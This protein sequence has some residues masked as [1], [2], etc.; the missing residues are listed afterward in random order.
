MT[1]ELHAPLPTGIVLPSDE[2]AARELIE[3]VQELADAEARAKKFL[4]EK[5]VVDDPMI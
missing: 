5:I 1:L 4:D 2:Q 3:E